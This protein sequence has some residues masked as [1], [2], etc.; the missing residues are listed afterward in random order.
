MLKMSLKNRIETKS[1]VF[2]EYLDDGVS[3]SKGAFYTVMTAIAVAQIN[4]Y[5]INPVV[6]IVLLMGLLTH[7]YGHYI[8]G[9]SAG[10]QATHPFLL[11]IPYFLIGLTNIK[12][13]GKQ[14]K[15]IVALSGMFSGLTFFIMLFLFNIIFNIINPYLILIIMLFELFFNYFGSDGKKYRDSRKEI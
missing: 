13:V 10:G 14:H 5:F 12:N 8:F 15:P 7:E 3:S 6:V 2:V 1:K 11:P 9:K 4:F